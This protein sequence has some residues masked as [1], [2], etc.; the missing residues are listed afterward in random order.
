MKLSHDTTDVALQSARRTF[1]KNSALC[2]VPLIGGV[3]MQAFAL[4]APTLTAT[5][6]LTTPP[7]RSRGTTVRNVKDYGAVGDGLRDDTAA[8][9]AA[10]NSLP[11]TGGTVVI[12]AG[13]YLI[14]TGKKINLRSLMHLQMDPAAGASGCAG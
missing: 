6:A 4:T 5:L 12:P 7:T 9:Q 2:A 14:D 13:T 10:I 11:T 8:I 3:S 1:I